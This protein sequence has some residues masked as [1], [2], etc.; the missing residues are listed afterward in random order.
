[1]GSQKNKQKEKYREQSEQW[2]NINKQITH[3]MNDKGAMDFQLIT[4]ELIKQSKSNQ[5]W[6]DNDLDLEGQ[7][8]PF[9]SDEQ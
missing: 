1:V 3:I 8:P 4:D 2:K 6:I 7:R 5:Y 9:G